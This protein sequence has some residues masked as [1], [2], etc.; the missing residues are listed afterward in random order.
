MKKKFTNSSFEGAP[1]LKIDKCDLE[2]NSEI[3]P[4][5]SSEVN[6][7]FGVNISDSLNKNSHFEHSCGHVLFNIFST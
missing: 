5:E 3:F 1:R 7:C 2:R 4:I 6:I